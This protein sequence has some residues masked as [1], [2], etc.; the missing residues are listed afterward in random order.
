MSRFFPTLRGWIAF[1]LAAFGFLCFPSLRPAIFVESG[2]GT[3]LMEPVTPLTYFTGG[4]LIVV[5]LLASIEAFRRGSRAD[6][7]FAFISVLLTV[8]LAVQYFQLFVLSVHRSSPNHALQPTR[9]HASGSAVAAHI[10]NPG[11]LSLGR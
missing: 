1:L 2:V 3:F 9:V 7:V 6:K 5:A 10:L 4:V 8:G 11:W